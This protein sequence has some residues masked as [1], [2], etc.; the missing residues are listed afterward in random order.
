MKNFDIKYIK[1]CLSLARKGAGSVS[2]NPMVGCVIVKNGK[3]IGTGYHQKFGEAHAEVNA[4]NSA[5]ESVSGATVYVNLEPCNYFGKTPPCTKL[6]IKSKIKR[7]VVGM[8]DPNPK[9]SGKGIKQLQKAGIEVEFGL[10]E[11]ETKKLN[12]AFTKYILTNRPFVTLKIAQTLDGKIADRN[13]KSKWITGEESLHHVHQLRAEYDAVLVGAGTI[14]ADDSLLTVRQ[15]QGR[16]PVRVILDGNFSLSEDAKIFHDTS[17]KTL[18]FTSKMRGRKQN[19]KK[20]YLESL[21]VEII[22]MPDPVPGYMS[23]ENI[24]K[25]LGEKGIASLLVEGGATTFSHFL[26]RNLADKMMCFIAPKILGQGLNVFEELP[27]RLLGN[28]IKLQDVSVRAIG[29]DF[30]I[31]SYCR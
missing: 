15:V 27:K 25:V 31:E 24:L 7:V 28:E 30:L 20:S 12:E 23:L 3:V 11:D 14:K 18:L 13:R 19:D 26:E 1:Q 6:L 8:L 16:N 2:P 10:L 17:A 29:S 22:E 21:G 5:R 9:V 4:I